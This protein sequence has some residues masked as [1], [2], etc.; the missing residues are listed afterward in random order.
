[1]LWTEIDRPFSGLLCSFLQVGLVVLLQQRHGVVRY[2]QQSLQR[3]SCRRH[4]SVAVVA[5]GGVVPTVVLPRSTKWSDRVF[6]AEYNMGTENIHVGLDLD[7]VGGH[8]S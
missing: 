5:K 7:L 3:I 6:M 4:R 2:G 8:P 1:M